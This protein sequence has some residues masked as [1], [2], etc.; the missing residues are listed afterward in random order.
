MSDYDYTN[1]DLILACKNGSWSNYTIDSTGD[2]G[3]WSSIAMDSNELM[4]I[5]YYDAT[6]KD[7]KYALYNGSSWDISTHDSLGD[8]GWETSIEVD[9][10]DLPHTSYY[11]DTNESLKIRKL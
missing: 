9:S 7:L 2:V 6:N 5:S 10:N 8:V 1:G 3:A 11:D 4:H